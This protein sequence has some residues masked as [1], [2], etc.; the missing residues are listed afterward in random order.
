MKK[1][2]YGLALAFYPI[3]AFAGVILKQ[4]ILCAVMFVLAIFFEK[5]EWAGRQTLQALCLSV[6]LWFFSDILPWGAS[7]CPI[8]VVKQVVQVGATILHILIYLAAIL[9]SIFGILRVMKEQEADIPLLSDLS[10]RAFGGK[11]PRE[12]PTV[13]PKGPGTEQGPKDPP[14][15]L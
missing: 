3:A 6:L 7:L 9:L 12:L 5:D 4:P 13:P 10:Y 15:L 14:E 11:K 1:G 2:K 8:P